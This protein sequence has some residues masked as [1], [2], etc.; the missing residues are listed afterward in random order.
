[1]SA[2]AQEK[3]STHCLGRFQVDLPSD[4]E[5]IGGNYEYSFATI[6]VKA[7]SYE[8]YQQELDGFEAKL[9]STKH[10]SG[11][12]LLLKKTSLMGTAES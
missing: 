3:M 2:V 4:A 6:E 7:I 11:S 10:K 5:Y 12:A 8:A 1:M 9:K